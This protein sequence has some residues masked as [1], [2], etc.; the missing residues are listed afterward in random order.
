MRRLRNP[1]S[2]L[3]LMLGGIL[4][5]SGDQEDRQSNVLFIRPPAS[6]GPLA[7]TNHIHQY[8]YSDPAATYNQVNIAQS[9]VSN[10][11]V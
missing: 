10:T 6:S 8:Q 1:V 9:S 4:G 3:L 7:T 2:L 11:L 5:S